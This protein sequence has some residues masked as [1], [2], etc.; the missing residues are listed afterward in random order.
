MTFR[1]SRKMNNHFNED[2]EM[3]K[4]QLDGK[5]SS[6]ATVVAGGCV[7][8]FLGSAA[9][10]GCSD[11][12]TVQ[13]APVRGDSVMYPGLKLMPASF[14]KTAAV[15]EETALPENNYAITGLW[16]ITLTAKGNKVPKDGTPI[17]FGYQTWHDDG[18][19][20]LNSGARPPL[21]SSF[22]MG[23]WERTSYHHYI[24][25][26]VTLSWDSTG[27]VFVGPG[28]IKEEVALDDSTNQFSGTF[29]IIQYATDE[30]TVLADVKGVVV[31]QRVTAR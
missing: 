18:T 24:L 15:H 10:A 5:V 30:K 13:P 20:I 22:C 16:K 1:E 19:E 25:N 28:N 8:L 7:A 21:T 2:D 31:G 17:D 27:T 11:V 23:V 29:E 26:H 12:G 4:I 3:K 9:N 6:L 14:I